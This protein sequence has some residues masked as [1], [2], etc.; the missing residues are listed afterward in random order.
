MLDGEKNPIAPKQ[1]SSNGD[2]YKDGIFIHSASSH[3]YVG[4]KVSTG[5][6]LLTEK[7]FSTFNQVMAGV[8]NFTVQVSRR[9][10]DVIKS[11]NGNTH[12]PLKLGCIFNTYIKKD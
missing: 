1:I 10:T 4:G 5:C 3:N 7:D 8:K 11:Q 2:G 9:V 6:L 12:P